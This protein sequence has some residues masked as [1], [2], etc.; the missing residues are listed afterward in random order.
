MLAENPDLR[1]HDARRGDVRCTL[2][3]DRCE[4]D[5]RQVTNVSR[6]GAPLETSRSFVIERGRPGA[7]DG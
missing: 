2:D 3:S 7:Q 5:L 1:Y 4:V 6:P